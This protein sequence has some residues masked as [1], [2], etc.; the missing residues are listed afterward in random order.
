MFLA[1][2]LIFVSN[3][4]LSEKTELNDYGP[5]DFDHVIGLVR[6][7]LKVAFEDPRTVADN[8]VS[9]SFTAEKVDR[10]FTFIRFVVGEDDFV[11]VKVDF[12]AYRDVGVTFF[13]SAKFWQFWWNRTSPPN[14]PGT[15]TPQLRARPSAAGVTA[16]ALV[17]TWLLPGN[18]RGKVSIRSSGSQCPPQEAA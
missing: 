17:R 12:L 10:D 6:Y 8:V 15:S 18:H 11:N 3:L 5:P 9:V 16:F 4:F 7:L 14:L 13:P 1:W 2:I